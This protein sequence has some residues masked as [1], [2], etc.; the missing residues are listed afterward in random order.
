MEKDLEKIHFSFIIQ[1]CSFVLQ[2]KIIAKYFESNKML[3]KGEK[4]V[5][6]ELFAF[7]DLHKDIF[8]FDFISNRSKAFN[9]TE[10]YYINNTVKT[11][12]NAVTCNKPL[13]FY[14]S[15]NM[16]SIINLISLL[17]FF[18]H[19]NFKED[20]FVVIFDESGQEDIVMTK[21]TLKGY[22]KLYEQVVLNKDFKNLEKLKINKL[23]LKAIKLYE[24]YNEENNEI[25]TYIKENK[26]LNIDDLK[27]KV[28]MEFLQYGLNNLQIEK[29]IEKS[30]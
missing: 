5:L 23:F 12:K 20:V 30:L 22:D 3:S 2:D 24:K 25:V 19:S 1:K 26:H 7:G 27:T 16:N 29:L 17:A 6:N 9:C 21:I 28:F 13:V 15:N 18:E 11:L 10:S 4:F 8:S 14:F